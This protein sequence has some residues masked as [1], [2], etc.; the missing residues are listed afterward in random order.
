MK[1]ILILC[2]FI[3]A[4]S[5]SVFADIAIEKPRPTPKPSKSIDSTLMIRLDK[6]AKEAKL[7]IPKN[8]IKQLRAELEQLDDETENTASTSFTR[9]QTIASG[10]FLSLAFVFGGVWLARSRKTDVK[11]NKTLIVGA[12]LLLTG[13]AATAA[14]ANMGPPGVASISSVIFS[15]TVQKYKFAHGRIKIETPEEAGNV[16]LIVPDEAAAKEE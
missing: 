15:P 5:L 6:N 11:A 13:S 8:Q 3:A 2:A 9:T 14:F 4:F 12:G 1:R 10:M 7:V 16:E